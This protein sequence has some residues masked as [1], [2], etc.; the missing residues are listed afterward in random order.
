MLARCLEFVP[1]PDSTLLSELPCTPGVFL[2]RGREARAEP[3]VSKTANLRRRME[4]LLFASSENSKRL[5][6]RNQIRSIEYTPTGSDFESWLLLY[7]LLRSTLPGNYAERLRLRPA[8]LIRL[9]WENEFPRASVSERI[10]RV[11]GSRSLYYGPF[12]SRAMAEQFCGDALDFFKVR[13]C[14]EDLRPDPLFPG[15]VYSEMKMCLAPCFRGCSDAQYSSEVSRLQSF[16]DTRGESLVG[17]FSAARESASQRLDFEEAA[18][19]HSRI[20][21]VRGVVSHIPALVGRIDLLA[22]VVVQ[23]SA[24]AHSIALFRLRSGLISGPATLGLRPENHAKTRSM[25]SRIRESLASVAPEEPGEEGT[26]ME[27]LALL[28]RWYYRSSRV[29]EVFLADKDG[30]LPMRRLTRGISRVY[31][32][33]APESEPSLAFP[34]PAA[35]ASSPDGS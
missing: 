14:S 30:G 10:S 12:P 16:F 21:K 19:L 2:L 15:C 7:Q 3:Y 6:L 8:A 22:G 26:I 35:G 31:R 34:S 9:Q 23:P 1:P 28:K 24:A 27:H 13:R 11:Q 32:G 25:E 4:R 18:V 20:E 29:G 5:N 17:E 33:E